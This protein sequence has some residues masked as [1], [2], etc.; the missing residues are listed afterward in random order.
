M[1]IRVRDDRRIHAITLASVY[2]SSVCTV[3]GGHL[4]D[5]LDVVNERNDVLYAALDDIAAGEREPRG[6]HCYGDFP[7]GTERVDVRG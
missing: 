1:I 4:P 6:G 5:A 3:D 7:G 2:V